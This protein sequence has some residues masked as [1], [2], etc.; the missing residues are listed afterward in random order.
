MEKKTKKKVKEVLE[1]V[2]GDKLVDN[3]DESTIIRLGRTKP[4]TGDKP[5]AIKIVFGSY[6]RKM[7]VLRNAKKLANHPDFKKLGLSPDKTK[8][9]RDADSV[10]REELAE[11]RRAGGEWKIARVNGVAKVVPRINPNITPKAAAAEA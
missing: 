7:D 10:L 11:K 6:E 1:F 8:L 9:E 4:K 5:R 2:K 3:L